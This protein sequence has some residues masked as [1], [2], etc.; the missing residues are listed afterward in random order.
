MGDSHEHDRS[1]DPDANLVVVLETAETGLLPAVRAT[2]DQEGVDY[3]VRN[4]GLSSLIVGDRATA[5]IGNA[6][7]PF[8]VVVLAEDEARAR[9]A[10]EGLEGVMSAAPAPPRPVPSGVAVGTPP[11]EG[12]DL[13][14]SDTGAAVGRLTSAQF[15]S[16]A[17]HLELES[18]DDSDYYIDG[19]TLTM[20]EEQG[21][22]AEAL[23][24]LRRALGTRPG[25]DVRW[26]RR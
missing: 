1:P 7:A 5:T 23:E 26:K 13:V 19:A 12:I 2:L 22:D 14:D 18:L 20:L 24:L 10:L 9:A 8:Q 25:M 4:T 15:D 11:A 17:E 3:V 16:I 6:D 21:A